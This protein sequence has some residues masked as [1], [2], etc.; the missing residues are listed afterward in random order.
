RPRSAHLVVDALAE[1]EKSLSADGASKRSRPATAQRPT[2]PDAPPP[3][4]STNSLQTLLIVLGCAV[5]GVAGY[6]IVA[7]LLAAN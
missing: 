5:L 2:V 6:K 7:M 3:A 4:T 1:V